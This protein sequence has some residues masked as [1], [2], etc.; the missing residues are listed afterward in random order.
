MTRELLQQALDALELA[1]DQHK[2]DLLM[3]G[4]EC[5]KCQNSIAKVSG[6]GAFPPS[7]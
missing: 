2:Y 1:V 7:A 5:R 3:T 4:D 6:G